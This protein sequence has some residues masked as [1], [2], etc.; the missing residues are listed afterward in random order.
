MSTEVASGSV[1]AVSGR[2]WPCLAVT[3][4]HL[5]DEDERL[6]IVVGAGAAAA[7]SSST[8]H[9]CHETTGSLF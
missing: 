3:V 1:S 2:V 5:A 7:T 4:V 8:A 6:S 9:A